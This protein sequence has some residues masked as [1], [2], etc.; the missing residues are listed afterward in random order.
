MEHQAARWW[1]ASTSSRTR[2]T[3][4]HQKGWCRVRR[5]RDERLPQ[6][7]AAAA[8][9]GRVVEL[10]APRGT[11]P[12]FRREEA[13]TRSPDRRRDRRRP[14]CPKSMTA[15]SRPSWTS[16]LP[17]GDVAMDP[18]WRAAPRRRKRRFPD[19]GRRA[20]ID[21]AVERC[22]RLPGFGVIDRQRPAAAEVVRP[23]RRS[24]GGIDLLEGGRGTAP[25]SIANCTQVGDPLDRRDLAIEPAV[26]RPVP[27]I[28]LAPGH[29]SPAGPESAAAVRRELRQPAA[30]PFPPA[31][32]TTPHSA[33]APSSL[34]EMKCPVVP[35]ARTRPAGSAGPPSAETAQ[36]PTG[37]QGYVDVHPIG[38]NV[39]LRHRQSDTCSCKL[40]SRFYSG[41]STLSTAPATKQP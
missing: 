9:P 4:P 31:A 30:V 25:R 26:D 15:L 18:D 28:T 23:G 27:G 38:P 11:P 13:S 39:H 3:L 10:E 7:P 36:P 16:R 20:G 2:R 12:G 19:R 22:N 33:A 40:P 35:A 21:L 14:N 8:R 5:Q 17:R 34:A 6:R 29:P 37:S 1:S 32:N 24:A 41:I